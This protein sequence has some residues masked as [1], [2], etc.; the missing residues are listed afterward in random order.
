MY[1]HIVTAAIRTTTKATTIA[2]TSRICS[3]WSIMLIILAG[4]TLIGSQFEIQYSPNFMEATRRMLKLQLA[5][6]AVK[7]SEQCS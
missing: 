4:V 1:D 2:T 3:S 5:S 7:A 6:H